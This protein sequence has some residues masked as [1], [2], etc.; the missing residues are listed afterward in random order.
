MTSSS[1]GSEQ[2]VTSNKNSTDICN[3]GKRKSSRLASTS[4]H[5]KKTN[6]ID[7]NISDDSLDAEVKKKLKMGHETTKSIMYYRYR[8]LASRNCSIDMMPKLTPE[9][10]KN[11]T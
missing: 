1:F 7:G 3:V 5:N 6:M 8:R 11:N 2:S 9:E 4:K 10:K